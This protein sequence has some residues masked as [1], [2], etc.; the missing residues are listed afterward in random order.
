LISSPNKKPGIFHRYK[1]K[2]RSREQNSRQHERRGNKKTKK[3]KTK[4][5]KT[6]QNK[7][8]R[9]ARLVSRLSETISRV[10]DF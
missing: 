10:S 7:K 4:R 9:S 5:N 3:K 8:V 6:K 1:E 2:N